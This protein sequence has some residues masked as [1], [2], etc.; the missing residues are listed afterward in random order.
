MYLMVSFC[1]IIRKL[2][3][4][5]I[6]FLLIISI[7]TNLLAEIK[8]K[9]VVAEGYGINP[10][11]AMGMAL[12]EAIGMVN[13]KSIDTENFLIAIE[14]TGANNNDTNYYFSQEYQ[15]KIKEKTKGLIKSYEVIDK[16]VGSDGL[17]TVIVDAKIIQYSFSNSKRKRIAIVPFRITKNKF[18][19]NGNLISVDRV[20]RLFSDN[21]ISNLVQT[22]KF[23]VLDREYL[24]ETASEKSFL[25]KDD[26]SLQ[27][28][29]KLGREL[30]AD[31]IIVGRIEYF[32]SELKQKKLLASDKTIIYSDILA[33]INYRIIDVPTKQIKFADAYI[34]N[35]SN[36]LNSLE[37]KIEQKLITFITNEISLKILNAIYPIKIENI[38]GKKVTLGMGGDL[39]IKGQIY[40]IILLGE[41]IV[42]KYT[43][44][45]L[46]REETVV[47]K[48]EITNVSSKMSSAKI[49]EDNIGVEKKLHKSLFIV[50]LNKVNKSTT[51]QSAKKK[52]E[53][54]KKKKGND[55]DW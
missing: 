40:D 6:F 22:R 13:G 54:K 33:E 12:S 27:D 53:Q 51:V 2:F 24:L 47:G 44:E 28:L 5:I 43:K 48:I 8:Y 30:F 46:G 20:Q 21:L 26:T 10:K 3:F 29:S 23:T 36:E 50:R 16:F 14:K 32:G 55:D 41:K 19:F 18:S 45:Y 39:V 52:I 15:S 17:W 25:L 9:T 11:E 38:S 49:I 42:D 4:F 37:G 34:Y 7:N 35:E 31:Y 1:K